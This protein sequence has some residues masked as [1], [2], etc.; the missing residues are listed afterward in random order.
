[1]GNAF[2]LGEFAKQFGWADAA[3]S[4][5]ILGSETQTKTREWVQTYKGPQMKYLEVRLSERLNPHHYFPTVKSILIFAHFYFP[6]WA[7]GSVKISNY[8]WSHDYHDLLRTRL[9]ETAEALR[10]IFGPFNYRLTVDTSPVHEKAFSAQAGIG[11]QGKNTLILNRKFGSMIF[12]GEILSDIPAEKFQ[13]RMK[14]PNRCGTC[15]RCID[16]CP[17]QALQPF[18]LD[19]KKC[20]SYWNLEHKG[21]LDEAPPFSG[22]LAGCDICQEVCPWNHSLAPVEGI[23]EPKEIL[24]TIQAQPSDQLSLRTKNDRPSA[25]DYVPP[26]K[27]RRNI[28]H[29]RKHDRRD[30]S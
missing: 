6:G 22:W 20:I 24:Q 10:K 30:S 23:T 3:V 7:T 29:I 9:A 26:Q 18:V 5:P 28:E 2:D 14:E 25:L 1:M 21:P 16:A 4:V 11:W 19:A 8:A 12:L 27:W 13:I 17:T 15:T